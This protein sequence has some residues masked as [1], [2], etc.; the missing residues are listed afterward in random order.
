MTKILFICGQN[1]WRSP[2]AEQL[3]ADT[4]GLDVSSAGLNKDADVAVTPELL[5]WADRIF[6]MEAIHRSRLTKKFSP[7]LRGKKVTCLDIPDDYHFMNE[8]LLIILTQKLTPMIGRPVKELP[9]D[10]ER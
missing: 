10:E 8:T 2:T 9:P 7:Y 6:V 4:P 3:Y 1:K 5:E